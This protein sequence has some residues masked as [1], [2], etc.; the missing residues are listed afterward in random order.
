[1]S[2]G[3][4]TFSYTGVANFKRSVDERGFFSMNLGD[5]MQT[6]AT[7]RLYRRLGIDDSDVVDVDRDTLP[8]YAG[9]PIVLL[10]NAVFFPWSFPIPDRIT[11]VF[12]GF[13][14]TER[15]IKENLAYFQKHAPIGCRDSETTAIFRK[16]GV[17][18]FTSGCVTMTFEPREAPQAA[19]PMIIVGSGA[20]ALPAQ[21]LHHMPAD[22]L[23]DAEIVFQRKIVH[24][25]PL[26][27]QDMRDA[28]RYAEVLLEDYRRRASL[29]VTPLHHA[30][31]PCLSSGIPVVI[32]RAE[33]NPR[34]SFLAEMMEIYTPERFAAIDWRAPAADIGA[35]RSSYVERARTMLQAAAG[36]R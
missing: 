22:L 3:V 14:A 30:A 5:Y 12:L 9:P 24:R 34:F 11:P 32:A 29:V 36:G 13:H 33:H 23:K 18:A 26:T 16:H 8:S 28:E 19:R 15:V 6:L 31:T 2:Y 17:E 27:Q 35:A 10:M 4:L 7:R 20:G 21:V 1:M 25:F